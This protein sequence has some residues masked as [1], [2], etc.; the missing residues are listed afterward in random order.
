MRRKWHYNPGRKTPYKR[1][2]N[3]AQSYLEFESQLGLAFLQCIKTAMISALSHK[4]DVVDHSPSK[5]T[6]LN[7]RTPLDPHSLVSQR[8]IFTVRC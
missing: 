8:P 7:N 6:F 1:S 3:S 2:R 5:P 4:A